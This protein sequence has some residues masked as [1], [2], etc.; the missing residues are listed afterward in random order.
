MTAPIIHPTDFSTGTEPAFCRALEL[1]AP[2]SR[3]LVLIHVL[4]ALPTVA[5]ESGAARTHVR[6][7]AAETSARRQMDALLDRVAERVLAMAPCPV[8]MVRRS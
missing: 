1:A 5:D 8:L 6:R 3:A 7:A 4:D 2:E